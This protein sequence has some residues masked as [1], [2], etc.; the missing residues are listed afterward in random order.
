MSNRITE[1]FSA[2]TAT[3]HLVWESTGFRATSHS[4]QQAVFS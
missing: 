1:S 2:E 3:L 4:E